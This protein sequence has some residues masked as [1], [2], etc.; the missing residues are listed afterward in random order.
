[1]APKLPE[2]ETSPKARTDVFDAVDDTDNQ[3]QCELCQTE[4]PTTKEYRL[5]V[6]G[7]CKEK[8]LP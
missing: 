8:Y 4:K 3:R 2:L 5:R 6:C 1:M 7:I